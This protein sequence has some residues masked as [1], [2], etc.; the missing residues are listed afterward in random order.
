[1]IK[2]STTFVFTIFSHNLKFSEKNRIN[3]FFRFWFFS[4]TKIICFSWN[5]VETF[6]FMFQTSCNFFVAKYL[7]L[8]FILTLKRKTNL[9]FNR[10]CRVV[11]FFFFNLQGLIFFVKTSTFRWG[12]KKLPLCKNL[13]ENAKNWK[14]YFQKIIFW[15]IARN[16]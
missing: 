11:E 10:S 6:L 14:T 7:F 2:R 1:M 13:S 3:R 9:I 16:F 8:H 4:R 15:M 5:S 12:N